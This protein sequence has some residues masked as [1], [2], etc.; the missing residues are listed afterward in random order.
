[1]ISSCVLN[2]INFGFKQEVLPK[3]EKK[4]RL[5]TPSSQSSIDLTAL[6]FSV[7]CWK[8]CLKLTALL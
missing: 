6:S 1:M 7:I 8:F 2:K 5:F 3:T 4:E